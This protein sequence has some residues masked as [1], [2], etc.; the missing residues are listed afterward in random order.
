LLYKTS[1]EAVLW[2]N[3]IYDCLDNMQDF[4]DHFASNYIKRGWTLAGVGEILWKIFSQKIGSP[5]T[6]CWSERDSNYNWF[7]ASERFSNS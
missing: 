2:L 7:D 6:C 4:G 5:Q 3:A 1:L